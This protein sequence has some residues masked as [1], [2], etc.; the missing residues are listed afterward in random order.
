MPKTCQDRSWPSRYYIRDCRDATQAVSNVSPVPAGSDGASTVTTPDRSSVAATGDAP[1]LRS[2]AGVLCA[3]ELRRRGAA[4]FAGVE[5]SRNRGACREV[6]G[7]PRVGVG[8]QLRVA[9]W[10]WNPPG[11]GRSGGRASLQ[12]IADAANEFWRQVTQREAGES[13]SIWLCGNSL[14]CVTALHVAASAQPDPSRVG[15][16]LRNPPPLI[17]VVKRIA[18]QYPLGSL[19][20]STIESLCEPMNALLHGPTGRL[21]GG[22]SAVGT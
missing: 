20:D 19:L 21:A 22:L 15:M 5:I 3:K 6:D 13:T 4:R 7:I 1:L 17:P 18:R 12:R 10:T 16:I 11:Y 14:G 9:I 8:R 2:A